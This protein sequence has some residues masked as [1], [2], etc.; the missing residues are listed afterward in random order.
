MTRL[1]RCGASLALVIG[2]AAPST[3]AAD[4][5]PFGRDCVPASGVRQ[6]IG[7]TLES[8]VA[9]FDGVPLDV[10]V[11]LPASG[12]GPFPVVA[13]MHGFGGDKTGIADSYGVYWAQRGIALVTWTARGFGASC[14]RADSRTTGCERGWTH[15]ADQ[16][17]EVRDAQFLL[18]SLVDEGIADPN[19]L[20]AA[21]ASYGGGQTITLAFLK[22]RMRLA[23]DSLVPW[24]SP[25]GVPLHLTAAFAAIGWSDLGAALFPN[26]HFLDFRTSA[27]DENVAPVGVPLAAFVT[28]ALP[29]IQQIGYVAPEG[30]D[31]SAD[32]GLLAEVA[33]KGD[34]YG[35]LG[36]AVAVELAAHHSGYVL[37]GTP[38]PL[39]LESGWNDD[40][41]PIQESLRIYNRLLRTPGA[42]LKLY[43]LD[44]GH[45]RGGHKR[46]TQAAAEGDAMTRF[47][48]ALQGQTQQIPPAGPV[49][50]FL[51][52]CGKPSDTGPIEAPSWA[53]IHPGAFHVS[54]PANQQLVSTGGD[55]RIGE[56]LNNPDACNRLT[57]R[58]PRG[59]AFAERKVPRGGFT[60]RG[61]PTVTARVAATG[62]APLIA[63][64]LWDVAPD[65]KMR[66]VA[67]NVYRL[68]TDQSGALVFQLRGNGYRFERGHSVRLELAPSDAPQF[69]ANNTPFRITASKLKLE[70][71]T[72]ERPSRARRIDKPAHARLG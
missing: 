58:R 28:G 43:L 16:R 72:R 54:A 39:L 10:D 61:Q 19:G 50:S 63:A 59:E 27:S 25:A 60:L 8:R 37:D 64:R 14:G 44:I 68:S 52:T 34:P 31:N 65:R 40:L 33:R 32:L 62:A 49:M 51:T 30:A 21:G 48:A 53:A 12:D 47:Q 9:S 24:T 45:P 6:C 17:Y 69:R 57:S 38:A 18:G 20:G 36:R 4:P 35:D 67:R 56:A 70:L 26:G 7:V 71:P 66:L 42:Q 41:F 1:S 3:S 22:D 13:Q 46:S 23:D 29:T 2:L 5:R 11:T 55:K 15:L